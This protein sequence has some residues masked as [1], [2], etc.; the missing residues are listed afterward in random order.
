MKTVIRHLAAAGLLAL[1]A[2]TAS[3]GVTVNYI[4]PDRFSDVSFASWERDETLKEL[5]EHFAK[6]GAELPPGQDLRIDVKDIDLAGREYPTRG[7]RDL[8]VVRS[9][10][11][12]WPRIDLHYTVEQD[13]RV[14]RSGEAQLRD[15]AFMD[16]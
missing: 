8:R 11:A 1:A 13:G 4:E 10:G 7:V 6:L 9:N 16:R 12:D 15:M 3:A 5:T 2:G 14:L